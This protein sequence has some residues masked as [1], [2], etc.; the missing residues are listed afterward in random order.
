MTKKTAP[1]GPKGHLLPNTEFKKI[2]IRMLKEFSENST[3]LKR[4]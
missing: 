4:T 1:L 3:A 2:I